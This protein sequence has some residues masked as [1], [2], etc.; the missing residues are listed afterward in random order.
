MK[1]VLELY[2][3]DRPREK[4]SEKG[5]EALKDHELVAVLLGS[6]GGGGGAEK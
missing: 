5:P 4:L 2:E 1:K 6:G 3:F